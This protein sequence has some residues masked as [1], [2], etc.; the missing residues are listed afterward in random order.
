VPTAPAAGASNS[1]LESVSA[2]ATAYA[3]KFNANATAA[4][5]QVSS[6]KPTVG[7]NLSAIPTPA[8]AT[9]DISLKVNSYRFE[10]GFEYNTPQA[11][12]TFLILDLTLTNT[13]RGQHD[14]SPIYL[15]LQSD[16]GYSYEYSPSSYNLPKQLKSTTLTPGES[17]RGELAFEVPGNEK[18]VSVTFEDYSN[19]VVIPIR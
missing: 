4:A 15:T 5:A 2:T 8:P 18:L 14:I 13:S 9:P 6:T 19:K 10:G 16:Q 1:S 7:T 3:G 11:G 17:T 12:Y